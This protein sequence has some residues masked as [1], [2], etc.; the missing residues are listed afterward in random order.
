MNWNSVFI[1]RHT[2]LL[3]YIKG[4]KV[5]LSLVTEVYHHKRVSQTGLKNKTLVSG[6]GVFWKLKDNR[7]QPFSWYEERGWATLAGLAR[8]GE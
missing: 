2:Y 4:L 6:L 5:V 3:L 8:G 7:C 1:C